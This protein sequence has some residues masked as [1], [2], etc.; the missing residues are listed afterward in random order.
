MSDL[1]S[2][3]AS[4]TDA[5][6]TV[7]EELIA[8]LRLTPGEL[9]TENALVEM[10]GLG[11]TPVREAVQRLAREGLVL[12][13]PR[14]G[15]KV[16][17][18]DPE[19]QLLVLEVRRELERL[20]SRLA[21]ERATAEERAAFRDIADGMTRVESTGDEITFMRFDRELNQLLSAAAHNDYAAGAMRLIVGHSRRFWF[22]HHKQRGDLPLCARL[23]AMQAVAIASG[24][25]EASMIAA[26]RLIDYMVAY[27]KAVGAMTP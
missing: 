1:A 23:H 6:Y 3:T 21:A 15:L 17:E 11:R 8:T 14:K 20:L 13:L 25:V 27:T 10:T 26:D 24:D 4:L 18:S 9:V 16:A 5:A 22:K 2:K 12:I 19:Q 7:L